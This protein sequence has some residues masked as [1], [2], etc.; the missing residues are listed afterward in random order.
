MFPSDVMPCCNL[1][2][3]GIQEFDQPSLVAIPRSTFRE[4]DVTVS[5]ESGLGSQAWPSDS[6]YFPFS[7]F[8]SLY[9]GCLFDSCH[10]KINNLQQRGKGE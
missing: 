1:A 4:G 6:K 7:S 10:V 2:L 9:S 5:G 8:S 3:S